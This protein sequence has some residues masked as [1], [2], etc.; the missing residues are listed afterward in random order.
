MPSRSYTPVSTHSPAGQQSPVPSHLA[1]Q[2]NLTRRDIGFSS[3]EEPY[4]DDRYEP[5]TDNQVLSDESGFQMDHW[6]MPRSTAWPQ[7]FDGSLDPALEPT[8]SWGAS[9]REPLISGNGNGP[10]YDPPSYPPGSGECFY[11]IL[12]LIASPDNVHRAKDL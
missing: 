3:S 5:H 1:Q 8:T 4:R 2:S 10:F 9:H 6:G 7:A 11:H 12:R